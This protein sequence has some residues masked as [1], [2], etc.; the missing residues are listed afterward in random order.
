M[1]EN[2]KKIRLTFYLLFL[3]FL[4]ITV[5]AQNIR[6]SGKVIGQDGLEMPGVTVVIK[7][8]TLGTITN[9]D[10]NYD[11]PGVPQDGVLVFSFVGMKAQE[12]AVT[13][14][15][16]INVTLE[17]ESIGVD[18]IVVVGYG[19]QRR[20]DIAGSVATVKTDELIAQP[21]ADLQGMLKGKVAG[22]YVTL[23]DARPGG[24]S[25][26]LL[27]GIRSLKGGN[28]PLYVVDGV[29]LSTINELNIDDVESISVLKDA[30]SQAI[31][32]ARDRK[33]VV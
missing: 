16:T 5:D 15:T 6:V 27:R 19:T 2:Q 18:E 1:K 11:I 10:G 24:D 3:M 20:G 29:P 17:T 4:A 9:F 28:S 23:G 30:S 12:I 31:Y 25:N 14:R 8:T 22:L 33:S 26:V 32:G 13:G 7:G 21:T